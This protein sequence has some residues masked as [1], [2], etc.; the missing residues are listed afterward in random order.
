MLGV[1]L[2]STIS[3]DLDVSSVRSLMSVLVSL[4]M[5]VEFLVVSLKTTLAH[6]NT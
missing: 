1:M 5:V 2:S 4:E 6:G 3:T